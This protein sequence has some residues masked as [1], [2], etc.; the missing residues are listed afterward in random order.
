[1]PELPSIRRP[2]W[3][4]WTGAG[5]SRYAADRRS[6]DSPGPTGRWQYA[7]LWQ[8]SF[9]GRSDRAS[10]LPRTTAAKRRTACAGCVAATGN[11]D[12]GSRPATTSREEVNVRVTPGSTDFLGF[13]PMGPPVSAADR[14]DLLAR[15]E[16][17]ADHKARTVSCMASRMLLH[18]ACDPMDCD[19]IA[20]RRSRRN[21]ALCPHGATSHI[22]VGSTAA[23]F[24]GCSRRAALARNTPLDCSR[25][26]RPLLWYSQIAPRSD[27]S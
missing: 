3:T 11:A 18:R 21:A 2:W 26:A 23:D 14:V 4:A 19:C 20:A 16:Q 5:R 17:A 22:D 7:G 6:A 1:M 10:A 12:S 25:R 9:S 24:A 8:K 15:L 27:D 13:A